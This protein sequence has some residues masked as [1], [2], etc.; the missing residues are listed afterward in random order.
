[1]N[2]IHW[3]AL[4]NIVN[5]ILLLALLLIYVRNYKAVKSKF[6]LGLIL[7]VSVLLVHNVFAIYSDLTFMDYCTF[8]GSKFPLTLNILEMLGIATL[9]YVTIKPCM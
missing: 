1:M 2:L 7:F 6:C 3:A 5:V 9:L 8:E 4:I